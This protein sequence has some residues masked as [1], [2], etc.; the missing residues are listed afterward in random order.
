MTPEHEQ[1][2]REHNRAVLA[3]GRR[4]GSPQASTIA[5]VFDGTHIVICMTAE[6]A[7]WNNVGRQP[8]V[9][10]VVNDGDRQVTV[11][12]RAQQVT[13]DPDRVR[14]V[15]QLYA[16]VGMAVAED[17]AAFA[18]RCDEERRGALR[19]TPESVVTYGLD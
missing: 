12:G 1:F 6:K 8:R 11:Y 18:R 2:L 4:D 13:A 7:K 19:I 17:D 10:V 3:T 16:A 5:Y 14:L 9:A 15:R